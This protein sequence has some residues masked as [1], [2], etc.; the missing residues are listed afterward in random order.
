MKPSYLGY[1]VIKYETCSTI[2]EVSKRAR[3]GDVVVFETPQVNNISITFF[4]QY[5]D[6]GEDC[7]TLP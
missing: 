2:Y 7:R 4:L 5:V 3:S 1:E 6:A